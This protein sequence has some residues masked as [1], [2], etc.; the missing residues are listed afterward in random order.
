M[1][2]EHATVPYMIDGDGNCHVY[3][4]AA[5]D[6]DLAVRIVATPRCSGR[7][8]ATPPSRCSSTRPWRRACCRASEEALA[9]VE[10]V[11][12]EPARAILPRIGVATEED[13]ATE[14]LALRLAVSVVPS[15]DAAVDHITRYGSGHSEAIV[16]RDLDAADGSAARSTPPPSSSTPRRASS[17]AASSASAPRSASRPRSS[18][19]AARWAC[20]SSP[21]PST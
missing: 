18:T 21:A 17:T 9:G 2:I 14:F 7:G 13:F 5:A 3:V 10:L 6:L 1:I 19:R 8:S 4:D 20:A 12:D 15:L 16:T 11:G